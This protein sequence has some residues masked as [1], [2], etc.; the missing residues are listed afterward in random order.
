MITG[1][2]VWSSGTNIDAQVAACYCS[3][4]R[5]ATPLPANCPAGQWA[6]GRA[7]ATVRDLADGF[8]ERN[9]SL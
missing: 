8:P 4:Y 3:I 1:R 5:T 6:E 2:A 9:V 7:M